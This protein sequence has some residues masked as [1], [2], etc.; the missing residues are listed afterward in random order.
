MVFLRRLTPVTYLLR[1]ALFI[2][3][4]AL[5]YFLLAA[6]RF[7]HTPDSYMEGLVSYRIAPISGVPA[8]FGLTYY[9][10]KFS[11]TQKIGAHRAYH[12]PSFPISS[13]T[14]SQA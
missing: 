9:I 13:W 10:F 1:A 4:T 8:L 12:E 3:F 2:Q 7:P 6:A 14:F 11:L 5:L